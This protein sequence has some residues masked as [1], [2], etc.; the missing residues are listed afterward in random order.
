MHTALSFQRV[1][2]PKRYNVAHYHPETN[3]AYTVDPKGPLFKSMG[4]VF[5]ANEDPLGFRDGR[6]NRLWLLPEE[7]LYLLERGNIDVRWPVDD[8]DEEDSLGVPMSLQ[9]AYAAFLGREGE[10][11]GSLTFERYS[12]YAGLKRT[13][14]SVHR[15]PS[16]DGPGDVP[17]ED[18]FPPLPTS[19]WG[20][21]LLTAGWRRLFASQTSA[22]EAQQK[23]GPLAPPGLY[24]SYGPFCLDYPDYQMLTLVGDV[25]R[26]LALVPGY[27]PAV[28]AEHGPQPT[29]PAFRITYHLWKPGSA[30]Y[31]KTDPGPPDFRIAVIDA[32]ETTVPTLAQLGA[33]LDTTPY[34]PP[35]PDAPPYAKFR[36]GHKNV[37]LAIV[38]QGVTSY[39]RFADS[40][41]GRE[42]LYKR[43]GPGPNQKRGGGQRGGAQRG[44]RGGGKGR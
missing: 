11:N 33:L 2:A 27:D 20:L 1:H 22:T 28:R 12:V 25:Y 43:Q 6:S 14:Y 35:K 10:V 3:M 17:G 19:T 31:K 39:L 41:L 18:C 29:D 9:G 37:I 40:G 23:E 32:R 34:R 44:P 7:V 36:N 5:P 26:R 21:G 15:A 13:G 8:D 4:K 16:W 30:T 42:K 24:R 38:D